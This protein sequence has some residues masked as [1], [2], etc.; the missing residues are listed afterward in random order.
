MTAILDTCII[1]DFLQ[2]REP[3]YE[4]AYLIMQYC[5]A[6]VFIGDITAK[7]AADIYYLTRRCTHSE[8]ESRKILNKLFS[9]TGLLSTSSEDVLR[10]ISS[11]VP[12]FEDAIMV[13]T[14]LRTHAECI[15]TRNRQDYKN[16]PLPVYTPAGFIQI[17]KENSNRSD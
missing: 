7:S 12:D 16:S 8:E 4:D 15:V 17:L 5:A 2:R 1:V 14:G 11:D 10:A 13:E 3:F 6:E 9:I